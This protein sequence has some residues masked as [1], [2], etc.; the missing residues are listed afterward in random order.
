MSD[1]YPFTW[2]PLSEVDDATVKRCYGELGKCRELIR[3][4]LLMKFDPSLVVVVM[5]SY[6]MLFLHVLHGD[7]DN[8]VDAALGRSLK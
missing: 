2:V 6:P 4:L 5:I 3:F 1:E 8:K 7:G